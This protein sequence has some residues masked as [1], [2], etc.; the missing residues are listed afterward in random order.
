MGNKKNDFHKLMI[1]VLSLVLAPLCTVTSLADV[2]LPAVIGDNMVLQQDMEVPIWGWAEAGEKVE[3][4][5]EAEASSDETILYR[6]HPANEDG[7]WLFKIGPFSAGGP[8]EMTITGKNQRKIKNILVGEVWVCSGQS[9]M[10]WSVKQAANPEQEIAAANYPNIRLFSVKRD[11]SGQPLNDCTASWSECSPETVAGFSAVAYF[12]GRYL[13]KE[14]DVPIGLINTSWGGTRTEPWTPPVGF[15]SIPEV[16]EI[17]QQIARANAEYG[18]TVAQSL[19]AIEEWVKGSRRALAESRPLPPPPTWP[20]HPLSSHRQPTGLYNAM[21]HPLVP[22]AIRG[23]IW[24]QGESNREDGLLYYQKMRALIAGWRKVWNQG[25]FPFYYVQL[26]PFRYG[27]DPF[28]LPQIWEAQ[29]AALA[30]PNTGMAVTADVGNPADIHPKNKQDVGKRLALWAL[31]KTYDCSDIV[32]SG[33]LY[34]SMTVEGSKIRIRFDHVGSGLASRD[35]QPLDWF[36]IAAADKNFAEAKAEIDG[37]TILAWSDKVEKP[38]AVRFA[39]HEEAEPNL[40]NKEGL[41]ASPFRTDT[42]PVGPTS[43]K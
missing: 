10:Q 1:F 20:K 13:S 17:Q 6:P 19:E 27:G 32:Y 5:F 14:L 33:P 16:R 29:K 43:D 12:F 30:I 41:P 40:M 37:G 24:Y 31:A 39:W 26:A 4:Q 35:G 23:A 9:N 8:Y 28:L 15:A 18:N 22:F 38:A 7:T 34:K 11:A 3:I 2:R 36:T 21:V 42:W 25:D